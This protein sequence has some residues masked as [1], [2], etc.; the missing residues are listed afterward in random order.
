MDKVMTNSGQTM[1]LILGKRK[2]EAR[3]PYSIKERSNFGD[4][5][6]VVILSRFSNAKAAELLVDTK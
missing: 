1:Q 6:R 3:R 2:Q 5:H 4:S